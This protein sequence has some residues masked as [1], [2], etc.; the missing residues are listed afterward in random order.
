MAQNLFKELNYSLTHTLDWNTFQD[1]FASFS[2]FTKNKGYLSDPEV[3][4]EF[5]LLN[6][7]YNSLKEFQKDFF[8]DENSFLNSFQYIVKD[9]QK[10]KNLINDLNKEHFISMEDLNSI[11]NILET[12]SKLD[13]NTKTIVN[14]FRLICEKD[15]TDKIES[16]PKLRKITEE[17]LVLE[18]RL[19]SEVNQ[20]E[21]A[22]NFDIVFERYAIMI[23]SD[24]YSKSDGSILAHSKTGSIL[25]IEPFHL[26]KNNEQRIELIA[27][28]DQIL[29]NLLREIS[30]KL[31]ESN[32]IILES[33]DIL[34]VKDF[35]IAI[36]RFNNYYQLNFPEI[37]NKI[38]NYQG[39]FHPLI[40]DPI[41]NSIQFDKSTNLLISG[42]NTGGKTAILKAIA[43]CSIFMNKGLGTPT[44][45][46][47]LPLYQDIFF[48]S[49]DGQNIQEGL[50]SFSSEVEFYIDTVE[51]ADDKSLVIIDEIF[52]S[53][54]SDEASV[55]AYAFFKKITDKKST[56][57]AS[58]HHQNLKEFVQKDKKF[59]NAHME[60]DFETLSPNYKIRIGDYD[61]SH[62]L[63]IFN[64]V[65]KTSPYFN[66]LK[67][68]AYKNLDEKFIAYDEA[69][70]ELNKIKTELHKEKEQFI[71]KNNELSL[72][73]NDIDGSITLKKQ[74]EFDKLK[75][76]IDNIKAKALKV[77]KQVK[78]GD[79]KN[80]N[81]VDY[82]FNKLTSNHEKTSAPINNSNLITPKNY[83]V[84]KKYYLAKINQ[85]IILESLQGSKARVKA[86]L[87]SMNCQLSDLYKPLK[88]AKRIAQ[89][90]ESLTIETQ[91]EEKM[92]YDCRGMR[93]EEFESLIESAL[94]DLTLERI[95]FLN[96]IHGHG[97]GILKKWLHNRIHRDKNFTLAQ[98]AQG[99][100]GMSVIELS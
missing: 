27:E 61:S 44:K 12:N 83:E 70:V 35:H 86:P 33:L 91:N 76:E 37:N 77:L 29:Y 67:E 96:I 5:H 63:D 58:T 85:N 16:H 55:L 41:K 6:S 17:I 54:S 19:R 73:L 2:H 78:D 28:R 26:K 40:R 62:A 81:K 20:I 52:N 50:S 69:L 65:A 56:L 32:S 47:S 43:L 46:A 39:L 25:Y 45:F 49:Q 99:N 18:N 94:S 1:K 66:E 15:G 42:A 82:A 7:H 80:K 84:G 30:L 57:Y 34:L 90:R 79:L 71:L 3:F 53:T 93:L 13:S 38:I 59:L 89:A 8:L 48:Y 14:E 100:D 22:S 64:R 21:K 10:V 75:S 31:K 9:D 92:E 51:K 95:P 74:K 98:G 60:F 11:F 4:K 97:D 87:G 23:P 68:L 24:Q 36:T 72:K 88:E